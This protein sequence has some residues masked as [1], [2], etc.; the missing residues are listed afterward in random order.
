MKRIVSAA[1]AAGLAPGAAGVATAPAAQAAVGPAK[2]VTTTCADIVLLGVA[3]SGE[4]TDAKIKEFGGY[5]ETVRDVLNRIESDL[6]ASS[7]RT[8]QVTTF[9]EEALNYPAAGLPTKVTATEVTNYVTSAETGVT[10]L[11]D[12]IAHYRTTCPSAKVIV[13]GYSQGAWVTHATLASV[14]TN[15]DVVRNVKATILLADPNNDTSVMYGNLVNS[16]GKHVWESQWDKIKGLGAAGESALRSAATVSTTASE[17][18][19][20]YQKAVTKIDRLRPGR[21]SSLLDSAKIG[22]TKVVTGCARDSI[23]SVWN[24]SMYRWAAVNKRTSRPDEKLVVEPLQ[25]HANLATL[26]DKIKWN[27]AID[28]FDVLRD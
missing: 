26:P 8:T 16:S 1:L 2:L 27:D 12:R 18:W 4:R 22:G 20:A 14:G 28:H 9:K 3:G 6:K 11:R 23:S 24:R 17:S 10:T 13:V 7:Y 25:D 5:G 15:T 21:Y 19:L